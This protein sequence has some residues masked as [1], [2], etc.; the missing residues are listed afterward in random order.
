MLA[1]TIELET[2]DVDDPEM[3]DGSSHS[4]K[5]SQE[6]NKLMRINDLTWPRRVGSQLRLKKG[7]RRIRGPQA[8]TTELILL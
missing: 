3:N 6:N 8:M 2:D 1:V 5:F 4:L 7:S